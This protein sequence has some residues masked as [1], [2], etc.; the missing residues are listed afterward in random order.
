M[1]QG[2]RSGLGL[3]GSKKGGMKSILHPA[4]ESN[5]FLIGA[6]SCVINGDAGRCGLAGIAVS[7][8]VASANWL[9]NVRAGGWNRPASTFV[10]GYVALARWELAELAFRAGHPGDSATN[11]VAGARMID[12]NS[13][14]RRFTG[15]AVC[16]AV[17]A[18]NRMVDHRTGLGDRGANP[19]VVGHLASPRREEAE[20][21][22]GTSDSSNTA[23]RRATFLDTVL[24]E[25]VD[26][27]AALLR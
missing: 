22:F 23:A 24:D 16:F 4:T 17:A 27:L 18:A 19:L 25:S 10:V 3:A 1:K 5:N 8:T 26:A 12:R 6:R 20:L 7:R 9:M 13:G 11:F 14:H 2:F 21:A 15:V